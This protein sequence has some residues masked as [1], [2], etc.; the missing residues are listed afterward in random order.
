[1]RI[2]ARLNTADNY[3]PI[4]AYYSCRSDIAVVDIE[5]IGCI[6]RSCLLVDIGLGLLRLVVVDCS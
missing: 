2:A 6:G 4:V 5:R 3:R 1:M